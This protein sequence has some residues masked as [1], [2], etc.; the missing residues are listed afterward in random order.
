MFWLK[1]KR[2]THSIRSCLERPWQAPQRISINAIRAYFCEQLRQ[3]IPVWHSR[4]VSSLIPCHDRKEH[5]DTTAMKVRYHLLD[6]RDTA[7]HG[8]D[9]IV[10][11]PVV[12]PDIRINRPD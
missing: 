1:H 8:A 5:V 3:S 11:I 10:L 12:D 2:V 6:A 4:I 7:R 9:Q